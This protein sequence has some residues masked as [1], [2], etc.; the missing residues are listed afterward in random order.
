VQ[1]DGDGGKA[2]AKEM[3]IT[4]SDLT[5]KRSYEQ[6]GVLS[7]STCSMHA[8]G[9]VMGQSSSTVIPHST[10]F[11]LSDH[12]N[13]SGSNVVVNFYTGPSS[14]SCPPSMSVGEGY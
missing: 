14:L 2:T 13:I 1:I 12:C 9:E 10:A 7:G 3:A 4:K 8:S 6:A 11:G 5:C